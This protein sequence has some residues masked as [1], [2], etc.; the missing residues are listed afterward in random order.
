MKRDCPMPRADPRY[1]LRMHYE[2]DEAE[3]A[4]AGRLEKEITPMT[5][6]T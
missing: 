6:A 3:D 5:A 2:L 1:F 4:L